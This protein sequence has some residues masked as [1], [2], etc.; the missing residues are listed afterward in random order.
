MS[1]VCD[2]VSLPLRL[3]HRGVQG[4]PSP[5]PKP[6][7]YLGR[8]PR[9]PGHRVRFWH[10]DL[11]GE[12]ARLAAYAAS[13]EDRGDT[14]SAGPLTMICRRR[15][16]GHNSWLHGA[17][18][19]GKPEDAAW[20]SPKDLQALGLPGGGAVRLQTAGGALAI[21]AV[22]ITDVAPGLVVVPHG[23]PGACQRAHSLVPGSPGAP[24]WPALD[25]GHSGASNT[26]VER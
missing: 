26:C 22:P 18:K 6:G 24:E 3:R 14:D 23:L 10:D 12:A 9:T 5:R 15:R 11:Q 2:A 20:L 1:A 19:D 17:T 21:R 16:L 7:K 13:L 25:D 4:L 8:G